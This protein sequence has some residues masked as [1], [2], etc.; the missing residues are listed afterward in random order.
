MKAYKAWVYFHA[1]RPSPLRRIWLYF[2]NCTC[3][4]GTYVRA[5]GATYNCFRLPLVVVVGIAKVGKHPEALKETLMR[6]Y[7]PESK[8]SKESKESIGRDV[9]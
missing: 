2:M 6:L 3:N 8:E 9:I 5:R 4:D 7:K 1:H